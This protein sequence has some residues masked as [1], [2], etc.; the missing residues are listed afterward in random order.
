MTTFAAVL[1]GISGTQLTLRQDR[2]RTCLVIPGPQDS[3][4]LAPSVGN[5]ICTIWYSKCVCV[6]VALK[7]TVLRR[8]FLC[9]ISE[10]SFNLPR[11]FSQE[12]YLC[13]PVFKVCVCVTFKRQYYAEC[14]CAWFQRTV[15]AH[16]QC[17][18]FFRE[19]LIFL[20]SFKGI[21][22]YTVGILTSAVC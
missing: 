5:H 11:A 19:Q 17:V 6:C 4:F 15:Y 18:V 7:K 14:S 22:F 8:V 1:L 16:W 9:L 3:I 20:V 13:H 12:P 2:R 21:S 10:S